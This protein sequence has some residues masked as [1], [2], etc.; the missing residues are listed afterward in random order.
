MWLRMDLSNLDP[1]LVRFLGPTWV[2][3]PNRH[4]DWF[5]CFCTAHPCDK[6]T[7]RP[8]YVWHLQQYAAPARCVHVMRSK[9]RFAEWNCL[10]SAT[11][12]DWAVRGLASGPSATSRPMDRFYR[13]SR[14]TSHSDRR[15]LMASMR[16]CEYLSFLCCVKN[17]REVFAVNLSLIWSNLKQTYK[18]TVFVLK[19]IKT[20][21]MTMMMTMMIATFDAVWYS[22][23]VVVFVSVAL[24]WWAKKNNNN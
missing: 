1:Y 9:N 23:V 14:R 5:S 21:M 13:Q 8:C 15:C 22:F 10:L 20:M 2:R 6:Q 11:C 18:V 12:F 16:A 4:L 17:E 19:R 7:H 3:P 24:C